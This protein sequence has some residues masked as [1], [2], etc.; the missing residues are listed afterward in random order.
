MIVYREY[1]YASAEYAAALEL[2]LEVLRRPLGLTFEP[3][4]LEGEGA[5]IHLGAFD[6]DTLVATL[7]LSPCADGV[8]MRQVA[9]APE[10]QGEGIGRQLVTFSESHAPTR[11]YTRIVLHARESSVA[12]YEK[13]G[14]CAVGETFE[15]VTVPHRAMEKWLAVG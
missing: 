7:T 2:R 1:A 9:V 13:L 6:E 4:D 12:F 3:G 15:E 10:R 14:Y 8:K 11:G 5:D